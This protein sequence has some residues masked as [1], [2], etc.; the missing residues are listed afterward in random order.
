MRSFKLIALSA[1]LAARLNSCGVGPT[2]PD[3]SDY[4]TWIAKPDHEKAAKK[5]QTFLNQQGV[6]EVV[7]LYQ[8]LRSDTQWKLCGAEPFN[9][10]PEALWPD[11][12]PALRIVRDKVIP[13]I[14]A[15]EAL[16]VFRSP[17]INACIHGASHS[18]HM[19]FKAIDMRPGKGAT[20]D[21]LILKMCSLQYREGHALNMGLGIYRGTR[22]HVD[23]AGYRRWG[24]DYHAASS[25]CRS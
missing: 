5:L 25:P 11:I 20:R 8:L 17:K 24:Y 16:S 15:V 10:P 4:Q 14:G 3:V 1:L 7:P 22:F 12:V 23:A 2:E 19:Q 13:R 9:V 6:G 21:Q 18:Y